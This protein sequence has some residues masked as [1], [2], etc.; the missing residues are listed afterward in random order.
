MKNGLKVTMPYVKIDYLLMAKLLGYRIHQN[1]VQSFDKIVYQNF[2]KRLE[3]L[4]TIE[5]KLYG[6]RYNF[7]YQPFDKNKVGIS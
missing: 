1:S 3:T 7:I 2:K 6:E 4:I 5:N